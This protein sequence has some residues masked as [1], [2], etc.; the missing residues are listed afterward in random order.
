MSNVFSFQL[1]SFY[2]FVLSLGVFV[3]CHTT[4]QNMIKYDKDVKKKRKEKR[5]VK[6]K[7]SDGQLSLSQR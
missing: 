6:K 1:I 7:V 2:A 5:A 4:R 3:A